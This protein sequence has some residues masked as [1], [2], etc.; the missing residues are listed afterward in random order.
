MMVS[1]LQGIATMFVLALPI[2]SVILLGEYVCLDCWGFGA[3]DVM[4][5]LTT[6][7]A[8]KLAVWSDFLLPLGV[9]LHWI[10]ANTTKVYARWVWSTIFV[11]SVVLMG[12]YIPNGTI[13]GGIAICVLF[14]SGTFRKMG[15]GVRLFR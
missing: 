2:G 15:S 7:L 11:S 12:V 3:P 4:S 8:V 9:F 5:S 14:A 1:L 6:L 10:I 13:S